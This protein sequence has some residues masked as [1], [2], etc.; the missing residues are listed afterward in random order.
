MAQRIKTNIKFN[1]GLN[2]VES[3]I[4]G[5]V[6]KQNGSWRGCRETD[7]CKKK[8]VFVDPDAAKGIIPNVLYSC[9]LIPMNNNDGFIAKTAEIVKFQANIHTTA[10]NNI[11]QVSVKF[12]NKVIIYNPNSKERR[13]R[14]IKAI[15]ESLRKRVDLLDANQTAEDFLDSACIVKRLYNQNNVHRQYVEQ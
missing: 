2:G 8:I 5:L 1:K 4:Y 15:A 3:R 12:G 10:R 13:Q 6:T 14:D 11:F 7:D 9:S